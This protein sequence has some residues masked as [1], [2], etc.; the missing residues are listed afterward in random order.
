MA[1]VCWLLLAAML[2][3]GCGYTIVQR[4]EHLDQLQQNYLRFQNRQNLVQPA[5]DSWDQPPAPL[6]SKENSQRLLELYYLIQAVETY[7]RPHVAHQNHLDKFIQELQDDVFQTQ[8][9]MLLR[10]VDGFEEVSTL[11]IYNDG[12]SMLELLQK[13]Y[14]VNDYRLLIPVI[15]RVLNAI[16][17]GEIG[18]GLEIRDKL[19]V[20]KYDIR[21]LSV[22]LVEKEEELYR[23]LVG[24]K[25]AGRDSWTLEDLLAGI[26]Q[27]QEGDTIADFNDKYDIVDEDEKPLDSG[28]V[29]EF[30][31]ILEDPEQDEFKT[32]TDDG[33]SVVQETSQASNEK[34]E[35]IEGS[36]TSGSNKNDSSLEPTLVPVSSQLPEIF[37]SLEGNES[38]DIEEPEL[39]YFQKHYGVSTTTLQEASP[40]PATQDRSDSIL[41][42]NDVDE[43]PAT[44]DYV[45]TENVMPEVFPAS[46]ETIVESVVNISTKFNESVDPMPTD[47]D[48]D[49]ES[50]EQILDSNLPKEALLSLQESDA[51]DSGDSV[52]DYNDP[53]FVFESEK[54]PQPIDVSNPADLV[55]PQ[56]HLAE[57]DQV[58]RPESLPAL[59]TVPLWLLENSS[60]VDEEAALRELEENETFTETQ[61]S[62]VPSEPESRQEEPSSIILEVDPN[63]LRYMK[64]ELMK[65][66]NQLV[67]TQG[68]Q[69]L[70]QNI[71]DED[72]G[73][74]VD[75]MDQDEMMKLVGGDDINRAELINILQNLVVDKELKDTD[76]IVTA[77]ELMKNGEGAGDGYF[78][79][80]YGVGKGHEEDDKG[81]SL[82]EY[83][84]EEASLDV[85]NETNEVV[86]EENSEDEGEPEEDVDLETID[87]DTTVITENLYDELEEDNQNNDELNTTEQLPEQELPEWV[88]ADDFAD[89]NSKILQDSEVFGTVKKKNDT[90][91]SGDFEPKVVHVFPYEL[92][93]AT[94]ISHKKPLNSVGQF[95]NSPSK[96]FPSNIGKMGNNSENRTLSNDISKTTPEDSDQPKRQFI[97][98]FPATIP[99]ETKPVE[100]DRV[101]D[102][103]NVLSERSKSILAD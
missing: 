58:K 59:Q 80:N 22:D 65:I 30:W 2:G 1:S 49:E 47:Y 97:Q 23:N 75:Q 62:A 26:F 46:A 70:R 85:E 37:P 13:E 79:T 68:F 38:Q 40:K 103:E 72:I 94:V 60:V 9:R 6:L 56:Q 34:Q 69:E 33:A 89:I 83:D 29:E 10:D 3:N 64:T 86:E 50:T 35:S 71:T 54:L 24:P 52:V 27:K 53:H 84:M 102:Q 55:E 95:N 43:E 5:L 18:S 42:E 17:L 99:T 77:L 36:I 93:N 67:E 11:G 98:P 45:I 15:Q 21:E 7:R 81:R 82:D 4:S 74:L 66:L 16:D 44:L 25:V 12:Q 76:K 48:T 78:E 63:V 14:Y 61:A 39:D 87:Q 91:S 51:T 28:R 19:S 57:G 31:V 101:G 92:Y 73:Q 100:V 32:E 20:L 41:I 88:D 90:E 8:L 96:I